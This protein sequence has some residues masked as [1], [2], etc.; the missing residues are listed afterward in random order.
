M[1]CEPHEKNYLVKIINPHTAGES[2]I[3]PDA[4]KNLVQ[5]LWVNGPRDLKKS[6]FEML[7][8]YARDVFN[9]D[10]DSNATAHKLLNRISEL[11]EMA[12]AEHALEPE[13]YEEI[14]EL[15][16]ALHTYLKAKNEEFMGLWNED[17]KDE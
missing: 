15:L 1:L 17:N 4:Y 5:D 16:G 7:Y 12:A 10:R 11:H 9:M 3:E 14:T 6:E 2:D 13:S 8:C